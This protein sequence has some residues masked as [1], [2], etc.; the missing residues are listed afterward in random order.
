MVDTEGFLWGLDVHEGSIQDRDGA[1]KPLQEASKESS[2]LE[3]AW[4]D[5]GYAGKLIESVRDTLGIDL[6]IVKRTDDMTGFVVL[7]HRWVV[8][9]TFGWFE[10]RRRLS[11]D[12]EY[13]PQT[14]QWMILL[15]MIT[16]MLSRLAP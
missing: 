14:S 10:K 2:R 5:E 3:K 11:K 12:Y 7:P 13:L 8:E 4:A 6:E 15:T 1:M 16:V 9:R